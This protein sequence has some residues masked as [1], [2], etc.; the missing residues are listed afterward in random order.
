MQRSAQDAA[1]TARLGTGHG[2]RIASL[3]ERVVFH[4]ATPAPEETLVI[5]YDSRANLVARGIIPAPAPVRAPQPFPGGFVP[6]PRG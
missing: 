2:E 3:A 4:R 6:D 5:F 1:R